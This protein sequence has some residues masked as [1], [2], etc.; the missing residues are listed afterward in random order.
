[1]FR[2]F[3]YIVIIGLIV[4]FILNFYEKKSFELGRD[5]YR[6]IKE[7][8]LDKDLQKEIDNVYIYFKNKEIENMKL[9]IKDETNLI[10]IYNKEK[11]NKKRNLFINIIPKQSLFNNEYEY[12]IF[13]FN[14]KNLKKIDSDKFYDFK[15]EM[16]FVE[17]GIYNSNKK[18]FKL[19][20]KKPDIDFDFKVATSKLDLISSVNL[21]SK[22]FDIGSNTVFDSK[23]IDL[24]L[25]KEYDTYSIKDKT[26]SY[27]NAIKSG[28]VRDIAI[29]GK[30][31]LK[32]DD[33]IIINIDLA[34]YGYEN[35]YNQKLKILISYEIKTN[36][37][38]LFEDKKYLFMKNFELVYDSIGKK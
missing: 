14:Y 32:E 20:K 29:K 36:N 15:M 17:S 16:K 18:V 25:E 23:D 5:E 11:N 7:N 3:K 6:F 4:L 27:L 26:E 1:M 35:Y 30:D 37:M 2:R 19:T 9:G 12:F 33:G 28:V 22:R 31:L 21:N 13:E 10:S 38:F 24:Y 8:I 34:K